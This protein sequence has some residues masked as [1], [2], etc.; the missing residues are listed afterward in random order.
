MVRGTP[1]P[2]EGNNVLAP[3][4]LESPS[5]CSEMAVQE[6]WIDV[7][8]ES[9]GSTDITR[10]RMLHDSLPGVKKLV[11]CFKTDIPDWDDIGCLNMLADRDCLGTPC[12]PEL[13]KLH[14]IF[15]C[16]ISTV[17]SHHLARVVRER[18][19]LGFPIG[20]IVV[21]GYPPVELDGEQAKVLQEEIPNVV[22]GIE[23]LS[24]DNTPFCD[25]TPYAEQYWPPELCR[26]TPRLW[27][28][29]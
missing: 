14:T 15:T 27:R 13:I 9:G 16:G 12:F 19:Q 1:M 20:K 10:L 4:Q 8:N 5:L 24:F 22:I 29:R 17:N 26:P 2:V 7:C 3:R 28:R 6:L 11:L 25:R 21:G 23:Q 18:W